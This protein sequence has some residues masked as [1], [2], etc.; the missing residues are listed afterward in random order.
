MLETKESVSGQEEM[1]D[2]D[3]DDQDENGSLDVEDIDMADADLAQVSSGDDTDSDEADDKS[4]SKDA[5]E[6]SS[7]NSDGTDDELA[8]FDAKL[9]QALG[10]R[11]AAD[12]VDADS[13][14]SSDE[15]MNDEQM[16][17]LDKHLEKVF[18]ERK[19]VTSQKTEKKN[20]KET[21]VNFKCRVLEL[22]EIFVKQK[23]DGVLALGLLLPVLRVIQTTKSPLV[24]GKACDLMREYVRLCKGKNL[25]KVKDEDRDG[26]FCL[27]Q[28][29][30]VEAAKQGS[31]AYTSA[32]SQASLL[33][34]KILA[35][36]DKE[37]L[38][39][40]V[41]VYAKSQERLL[42]DPRCKMKISFFFDWLN[43]CVTAK[44]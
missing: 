13:G 15:D 20:A 1:F 28:L 40:A 17:A 22:L 23:H 34:V 35:A 25:P 24:S 12:D 44:I 38:R 4:P 11:L 18:R 30:H 42:L 27:L 5:A 21:I 6:D 9:A 41:T 7:H 2:R 14:E 33:L 16:E 43:W 37:N 31:N 8:V 36:Q 3:D 32:C 19:K 26:M 10:T 39:Q 29:V